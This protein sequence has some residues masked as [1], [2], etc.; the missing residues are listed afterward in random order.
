M[1]RVL[2]LSRHELMRVQEDRLR[3]MF[4]DEEL[5]IN[6]RMHIWQLTENEADDNEANAKT[7]LRMSK[8][9]DVIVGV[10]PPIAVVG[11]VMCRGEADDGNPEYEGWSNP[12]VLTPISM[13]SSILVGGVARKRFEF[14]RWQ[15][16]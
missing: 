13:N 11:L 15:H 1:L 14:Y 6:C 3:A 8:E 16:M 5:V 10:F 9:A 4:P 7:W 2:W 12:K